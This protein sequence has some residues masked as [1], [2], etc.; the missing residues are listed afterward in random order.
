MTVAD[1]IIDV[2]KKC[3]FFN[4]DFEVCGGELLPIDKAI[5]RNAEGRGCCEKVKQYLKEDENECI[6]RI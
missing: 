4:E 3:I 1:V 5:L 2:C 6:R